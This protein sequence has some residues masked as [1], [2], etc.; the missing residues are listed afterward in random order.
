MFR[1]SVIAGMLVVAVVLAVPALA[2]EAP[3]EKPKEAVGDDPISGTWDGTTLMGTQEMT[4]FMNLRVD[5]E[6]VSGEIGNYE[7]STPVSGTWVD[8]KLTLN[9]SYVNGEPVVMTAK[10]KDG[11][12]AGDLDMNAGQFL[13]TWTAKKKA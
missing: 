3:Q 9:F 10:L 6:T 2:Q 11:Q 12:L 5:K 4:F 7:G 13:A 8:G 1:R